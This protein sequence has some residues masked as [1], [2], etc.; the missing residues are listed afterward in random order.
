MATP[1]ELLDAGRLDAALEAQSQEVKAN[2]ADATRRIFLFEL[3]CFAGQWDRAEKQIDVLGSESAQTALAVGV[4]KANVAAER[5]R[6]KLYREGAAPHFLN[7]PPAYVDSQVEAIR[8]LASGDAAGARTLLDR[9]E[10]ERPACAGTW[11]E[12]PFSDFRDF[13]DA[14]GGVLELIVKDKYAWLPFEQ[15]RSITMRPPTKLRDLL[16]I[17]TRVEAIDG[18][19]GEVFVP[20]LYA[21]SSEGED[22]KVRLGRITDWKEIGDGLYSGVGQR[23]FLVDEADQPVLEARTIAFRE[24]PAEAPA[25]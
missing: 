19:I 8:K 25:S 24:R 17:P 22:D 9:V 14:V 15:I 16:W 13:D 3:L 4:Y 5:Q 10:E 6:A 21:G 2:P 20:A 18:T 7:E 1:K 23:L 12:K 11:N